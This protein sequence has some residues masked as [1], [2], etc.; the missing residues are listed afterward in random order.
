LLH[1]FSQC[2]R[3]ECHSRDVWYPDP[4]TAGVPHPSTSSILAWDAFTRRFEEGAARFRERHGTIPVL[5]IDHVN[6]LTQIPGSPD[7]A[8]L[9]AIQESAKSWA[10]QGIAKVVLVASTG[11]A[12]QVLSGM[13]IIV[14]SAYY[15]TTVVF[16]VRVYLAE[17]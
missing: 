10:D 14:F 9:H 8:A 3:I 12:G 17:L 11:R 2:D 4:A 16:D 15:S 13:T 7:E 6:R 1:F 5:V